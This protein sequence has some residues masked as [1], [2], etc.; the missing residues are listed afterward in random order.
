MRT[1]TAIVLAFA[2]LCF[3]LVSK[4]KYHNIVGVRA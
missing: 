3:V 2:T 1:A 4:G